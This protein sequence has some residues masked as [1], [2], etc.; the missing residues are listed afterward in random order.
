MTGDVASVSP[1][2]TSLRTFLRDWV[3][4]F[5]SARGFRGRG[6]VFKGQRGENSIVIRFQTRS[7]YFTC[8]LAATSGL[9]ARTTTD[10]EP[11]EHWTIRLGPIVFGYDK[12]W[13]LANPAA[14]ADDLLP[15]LAE[16]IEYMEPLS[17]D[18]GLRDAMLRAAADDPRGEAPIHVNQ[19]VRLVQALGLPTWANPI[20]RVRDGSTIDLR[21][22]NPLT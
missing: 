19:I 8:D 4:P 9:L 1:A 12:W 14:A 16:G 18:T 21:T 10:W 3:N 17:S 5:L 22:I 11:P 15:S 6:Q 20:L 2:S 13:D 7:G